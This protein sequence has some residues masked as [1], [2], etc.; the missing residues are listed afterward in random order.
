MAK[1]KKNVKLKNIQ[2]LAKQNQKQVVN[3]FTQPRQRRSLAKNAQPMIR[4]VYQ[5]IPIFNP[6]PYQPQPVGTVHGA[7]QGAIQGATPG[8]KTDQQV[9][10]LLKNH[11]ESQSTIEGILEQQRQFM[12]TLKTPQTVSFKDPFPRY[13][14]GPNDFQTEPHYRRHTQS[15]SSAQTDLRRDFDLTS[16]SESARTHKYPADGG[17][18]TIHTKKH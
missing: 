6:M 2:L 10:A 5:N 13:E 11:N 7:I 9:S 12:K 15:S 16:I 4:T 14:P 8:A 18:G 1:R 17:G 3:V